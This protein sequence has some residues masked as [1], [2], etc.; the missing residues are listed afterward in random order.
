MKTTPSLFSEI[1]NLRLENESLKAKSTQSQEENK[2]LKDENAFLRE[3]LLLLKRDKFG[4]KSERWESPEQGVLFN[5]AEVESKK[6]DAPRADED[7]EPIKVKGHTKKR[8][9]RK[10]LPENLPREVV[11][12]ELPPEERVSQDGTPLKVIGYEYSEKLKYEPAKVSV[13]EY[14]RAKYGADSGDYEKTAP[15]VPSIIPK[16]IATPELLAAIVVAKY[17]DGLPLYRMEEIFDR[18]GIELYRSTM[19]RW[20]IKAAEAC[21]P[22]WNVLNDK[23]IERSYVACDE[24]VLHVLKE[25]GRKAENKSWM[26][27]RSTPFG[28]EKIALFDYSISRSQSV[29][30]NLFTD[31]Q[32]F[33][34]T[35]GLNSY[36]IL[37]EVD[38]VT[39]IGCNMH[40][41]RR[42]EQALTVGAKSG[43]SLAEVGMKFY[44]DLYKIEEDIRD[45]TPEERFKIRN[46]LS[47]PIWDEFELWVKKNIKKVPPKSKI[48]QAFSYFTSEYEYLT[49]YLKNGCL[50]M[51]NGHTERVIRKFAIGRNNWMFADTEDGAHASSV[52]YSLVVSA[53]L[54]SVNPYKALVH[55]FAEIPKAKTIEDY[56][57]LA[58]V[59]LSPHAIP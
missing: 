34:Q 7:Q 46:E 3:Q 19:A 54:N 49:G 36:E 58:E 43:Q 50:E 2:Y 40:S 33:L 30:K 28:S 1:E 41:R 31:F 13:I 53:K 4:K 39:R 48:G 37:D 52:L 32:G 11:V 29:I 21:Q 5:E 10:P 18:Q 35:D 26:I 51:D 56:E 44:K 16:G 27:V 45:K 23:L 42:F 24:T 15:P 20:V 38:G 25:K 57:R 47:K 59:V 55:L 17:S 8:G 22:I 9:H 12:V 14:H 6:P